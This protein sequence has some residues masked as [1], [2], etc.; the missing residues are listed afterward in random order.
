MQMLVFDFPGVTNRQYDELCR[1]LNDGQ[2]LIALTDFHRAGYKIV[3][4]VAGPTPDGGWRVVD[5]WESEEALG[6]F[7]QRLM[8]LLEQVGI[9]AVAP[10]VFPVHNVVTR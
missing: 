1:A 9:P 3:C 6:H 7:R 4:H 2:P 5:V 8:P 10:Q